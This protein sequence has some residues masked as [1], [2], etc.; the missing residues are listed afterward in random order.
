MRGVVEG[1]GQRWLGSRWGSRSRIQHRTAPASALPRAACTLMATPASSA[2]HSNR[3]SVRSGRG[4][5]PRR[6]K[7][8][9]AF[10]SHTFASPSSTLTHSCGGAGRAGRGF[11]TVSPGPLSWPTPQR[12]SPAPPPCA[13]Q[14]ARARVLTAARSC[15]RGLKSMIPM[16]AAPPASGHFSRPS[17]C[18]AGGGGGRQGAGRG[19]ARGDD[20]WLHVLH[21]EGGAQ[22]AR[23]SSNQPDSSPPAALEQPAGSPPPRAP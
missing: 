12:P 23:I 21:A 22:R 2:T 18:V 20:V 17:S 14:P 16:L 8:L 3:R 4:L 13:G 6:N 10:W 1:G 19:R 11:P 9:N 5:E 15:P 7:S